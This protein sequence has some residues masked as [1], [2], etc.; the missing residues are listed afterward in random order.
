MIILS[1]N[2][3]IQNPGNC[4]NTNGYALTDTLFI[5]NGASILLAAL[6]TGAQLEVFVD[7]N[8]DNQGSGL[9]TITGVKMLAPQ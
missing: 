5:N 2:Q 8:C 9:P 1:V 4:G 7:G 6:A 3:P